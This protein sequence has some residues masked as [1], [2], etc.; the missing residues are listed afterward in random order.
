MFQ[1]AKLFCA[2]FMIH[3]CQSSRLYITLKESALTLLM[4]V[5]QIALC[6]FKVLWG[7]TPACTD[8]WSILPLLPW[9]WRVKLSTLE[10]LALILPMARAATCFISST[11]L[12]ATRLH[13]IACLSCSQ[14]LSRPPTLRTIRGFDRWQGNKP[15]ETP[16]RHRRRYR[17]MASIHWLPCHRIRTLLQPRPRRPLKRR[18]TQSLVSPF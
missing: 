5:K 13:Q 11:T 12:K 8:K 9:L 10:S 14:H 6:V 15:R 16:R 2:Y 18:E 17:T 3:S 1:Q 4:S 7:L